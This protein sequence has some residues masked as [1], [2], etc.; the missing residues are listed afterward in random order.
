MTCEQKQVI[1]FPTRK[2]EKF[3]RRYNSKNFQV[4]MDSSY[5]SKA[6]SLPQFSG[7]HRQGGSGFG[8]LAAGI[9]RVALP[10]ARRFILPTVKLIGKELLEQSFQIYWT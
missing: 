8:A 7:Y 3:S 10:I 2:Q 5:A 4:K 6:T 9:G 1:W